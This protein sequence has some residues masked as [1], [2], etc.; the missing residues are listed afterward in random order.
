[1]VS[2]NPHSLGKGE[3]ARSIRAGSTTNAH[4]YR[5]NV[6]IANRYSAV[7][8]RTE[9]EADAAER[10]KSVDSVHEKFARAIDLAITLCIDAGMHPSEMVKPLNRFAARCALAPGGDDPVN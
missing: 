9:R 2:D 8:G 7:P 6:D 1:M 10:G 5:R 3:V 4:E